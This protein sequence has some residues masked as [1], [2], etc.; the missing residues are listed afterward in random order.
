MLFLFQDGTTKDML[1]LSKNRES[2]KF[3]QNIQRMA[4]RLSIPHIN[5]VLS[6]V[7]CVLCGVGVVAVILYS[8]FTTK[9]P[10]QDI[11][12]AH[13]IAQVMLDESKFPSMVLRRHLVDLLDDQTKHP[14]VHMFVIQAL[15]LA[16][17]ECRD[18]KEHIKFGMESRETRNSSSHVLDLE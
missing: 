17:H 12:R 13:V 5:M 9:D 4:V 3:S 7:G 1:T 18:D 15:A 16:P 6:I 10:L 8:T 14:E 11:D 2:L